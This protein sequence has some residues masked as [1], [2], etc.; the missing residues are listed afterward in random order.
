MAVPTNP[1]LSSVHAANFSRE[2]ARAFSEADLKAAAAKHGPFL[3][4]EDAR[5]LRDE[6]AARLVSLRGLRS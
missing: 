3:L 5:R 2:I 1:H 6:Y 4:G